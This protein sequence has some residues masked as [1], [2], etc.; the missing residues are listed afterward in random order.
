[1][2]LLLAVSMLALA[3]CASTGRAPAGGVPASFVRTTADAPATRL[4]PVREGQTRQQLW[5]LLVETLDEVGAVDVRDNTAGFVMTTW[6]SPLR[7]GVPDLRYRTRVVG[8]YVGD[9]R[10]LQVRVES[11][12]RDKGDEWQLGYDLATL[13][14][15]TAILRER[16]GS[17]D[18]RSARATS[19]TSR[20]APPSR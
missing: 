8:R 11:Q 15:V 18:Q 6:E 13:E 1:M 10:Q 16:V 5:R 9:W 12:W 3:G 14:R 20:Q 7:D 17:R 4:I 2:R 19:S